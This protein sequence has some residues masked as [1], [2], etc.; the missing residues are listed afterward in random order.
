MIT[1]TLG[2]QTLAKLP[3]SMSLIQADRISAVKQTYT[4]VAFF[5]WGTTLVGKVLELKWPLLSFD[6]FDVLDTLFQADSSIVFDPGVPSPVGTY[7]VEITALDGKYYMQT[8]KRTDVIMKL[9]ILA[10]I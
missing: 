10:V 5:S 8:T 4:G 9:L 1:M 2:G 7:T 3:S 6:E